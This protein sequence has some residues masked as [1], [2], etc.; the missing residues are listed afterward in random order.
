[1]L[2]SDRFT[3][4]QGKTVSWLQ[5][6]GCHGKILG[7]HVHTQKRLKKHCD[8]VRWK[9]SKSTYDQ[10]LP[11]PCVKETVMESCGSSERCWA[12]SY[13]QLCCVSDG[14]HS[15]TNVLYPQFRV[16]RLTLN[17]MTA[18]K[19]HKHLVGFISTYARA[20]FAQGWIQRGRSPPHQNV[21]K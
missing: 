14:R 5:N 13:R 12:V 20:N 7:C 3:S 11:V 6:L 19:M 2:S 10:Q 9:M 21:R 4:I 16:V 18:T 8:H 17:Q 1:M 15:K